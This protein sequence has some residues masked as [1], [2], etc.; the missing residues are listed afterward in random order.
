VSHFSSATRRTF[1]PPFTGA[2]G[3]IN[4][5]KMFLPGKSA[6]GQRDQRHQGNPRELQ[7][8]FHRLRHFELGLKVTDF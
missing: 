2:T 5:F 8:F 7:F 3:G 6:S 4:F 1:Q